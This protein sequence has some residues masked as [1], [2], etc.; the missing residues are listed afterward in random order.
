VHRGDLLEHIHALTVFRNH[1]AQPTDLPLDT[2]KATIGLL[3]QRGCDR[4][5]RSGSSRW[6]WNI[7]RC[8]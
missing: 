1:L 3:L 8:G 7:S 2:G 5:I 4:K 6:A